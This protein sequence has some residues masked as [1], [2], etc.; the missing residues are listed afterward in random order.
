MK[1]N[2]PNEDK[3]TR[4]IIYNNFQLNGDKQTRKTNRTFGLPKTDQ[5]YN[6]WKVKYDSK[7][8]LRT[9]TICNFQKDQFNRKQVTRR[10]DSTHRKKTIRT[11][12]LI[13]KAVCTS[14]A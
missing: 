4:I 5:L 10:S 14:G 2:R 12:E 6:N 7:L 11:R 3:P 13:K 1:I 8:K 9:R